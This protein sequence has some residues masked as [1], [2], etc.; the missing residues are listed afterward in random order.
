MGS[1]C[2]GCDHPPPVGISAAGLH[3]GT[4]VIRGDIS[5]QFL[6]GLLMAAP[7]ARSPVALRVQGSLVSQPYV[8]MTTGVMRAFGV[9]VVD[10]EFTS[11]H[12]PSPSCYVGQQYAIEPDASAASYF[13]AAAAISGGT[14][15]VRGLGPEALQGDVRFCDCLEQM[16]C[17]VRREKTQI[18]VIGRSHNHHGHRAHPSQGNRSHR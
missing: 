5:S 7:Y 18:T 1:L 10:K 16:G 12:I 6:S 3:G 8:H 14:V 11:F 2:V 13:G 4:A 15:T 17:A 9:P